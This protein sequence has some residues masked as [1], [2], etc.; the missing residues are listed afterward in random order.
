MAYTRNP[1]WKDHPDT[2]TPITA[3][4]LENIEQGITDAATVAD[5]AHALALSS[6]GVTD[7]GALTGL[8]DD[9]HTQYAL[10]DG[11]RGSFASVEQGQD[12]SAAFDMVQGQTTLDTTGMA[13]TV[14]LSGFGSLLL[15]NAVDPVTIDFTVDATT[16]NGR[17]VLV[18]ISSWS[19]ITWHANVAVSGTPASTASDVWATLIAIGGQWN[20]VVSEAPAIERALY[21]VIAGTDAALAL[22][23]VAGSDYNIILGYK[24]M[25]AATSG[26]GNVVIG[27]EAVLT[28][29]AGGTANVSIGR[30]AAQGRNGGTSNVSIG[31]L[32]HGVGPLT[33]S[34]NLAVGPNAQRD[35]TTGSNNCAFGSA[36]LYT[37]TT[38]TFNCAFGRLA[39]QYVSTGSNNVAIGQSSGPASGSGAVNNTVSVGYLSAASGA[40]S[41]AIGKSSAASH[42]NSVAL[43]DGS[44]TTAASQVM[45]GAKDVEITDT[46]KGIILKSP[47]GT[48]YRV[49]VAN[50]GTL[51]VTAA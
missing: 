49:T 2:S 50:G 3:A 33:G 13:G 25:N 5:A 51:T 24:A 30:Y 47:D 40:D 26:T 15:I 6:G 22:P 10:A 37:A 31:D 16:P 42:A 38:G 29:T 17:T 8:A 9:D 41:V 12:G 44:V 34:S 27:R 45:V 21:N 48:R 36:A 35:L 1:Q 19:N 39:G 28:G 14:T 43:G 7:H 20:L 23:G 32:A 4:K 46:T 11:T 18:R